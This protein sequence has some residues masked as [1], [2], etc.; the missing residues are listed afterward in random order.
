VVSQ[1][2]DITGETGTTRV[3]GHG[4]LTV[5]QRWSDGGVF[6][7]TCITF[8]FDVHVSFIDDN[9]NRLEASLIVPQAQRTCS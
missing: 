8:L 9:A 3:G 5:S 7:P 6:F 2:V 1:G 4:A